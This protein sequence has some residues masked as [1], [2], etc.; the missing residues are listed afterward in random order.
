MPVLAG[1]MPLDKV[2]DLLSGPVGAQLGLARKRMVLPWTTTG[3]SNRQPADEDASVEVFA[4]ALPNARACWETIA[5]TYANNPKGREYIVYYGATPAETIRLTYFQVARQ[6]QQIAHQLVGLGL[7]KGDRVGI[8][9]RNYPEYMPTWWAIVCAGFVVVPLN[10]WLTK[11]ELEWCIKDAGCRVLFVDPERVERLGGKN[12]KG[13]ADIVHPKGPVIHYVTVR[14]GSRALPVPSTPFHHLLDATLPLTLPAVDISPFDNMQILYSSG[15]TGH[16][17][18][19]LHH[20]LEWAQQSVAYRYGVMRAVIRSGLDVPDLK[21]GEL[22]PQTV[23]YLPV[24]LF[25]LTGIAYTYG[26]SMS[27]GKI[28]YSYKWD[29]ADGI[30]I[31][32][33]EQVTNFMGVPTMSLQIIESPKFN[34]D[35]V[36]SLL[37]LGYGGAP[38]PA[39]LRSRAKAAFKQDGVGE[40]SNTYGATECLGVAANGGPDYAEKPESVGKPLPFHRVE[41]R[42]TDGRVLPK[43]EVGDIWIKS[44]GVAKGYWNNEKASASTFQRGW[45]ST[46]GRFDED[47]FLYLLDRSKDMLIRGGENVYCTEVEAALLSHPDVMDAAVFG[48]PHRVLGEEVGASVR[49]TPARFGKVTSEEL[50]KHCAERI[51]KFKVPAYIQLVNEALPATPSGKILKRE[52]KIVVAKLAAKDL[53]GEFAAKL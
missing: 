33:A 26:A 4:D 38:G 9:M 16:P 43:G 12:G 18:G 53:G 15:T 37:S 46:G 14:C 30:D 44:W 11:P 27:G 29:A 23:W 8:A 42:S 19:V 36:K 20:H 32:H 28:V 1:P 34:L 50:R 21:E 41:I 47:G 10:A 3:E 6:V 24:P 22:P 49:I 52:I 40:P 2:D 51:A 35:K 48:I 25:H 31:I 39:A 45:Y 13:L 17:K 5:A 7:K